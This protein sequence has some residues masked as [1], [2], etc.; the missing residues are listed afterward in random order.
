ML[1]GLQRA[2]FAHTVTHIHMLSVYN[3]HCNSVV[4]I[5]PCA[6]VEEPHEKVLVLKDK[7]WLGGILSCNKS[8]FFTF[9][10]P[11]LRYLAT[12]SIKQSNRTWVPLKW[13]LP[14]E[15]GR[16]VCMCMCFVQWVHWSLIRRDT[17]FGYNGNICLHVCVCRLRWVI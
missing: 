15:C 3:K 10:P 17:S 11:F 7:S 4:C 12:V 16:E 13:P 8:V 5:S 2:V 6:I 14:P 1:H 9:F